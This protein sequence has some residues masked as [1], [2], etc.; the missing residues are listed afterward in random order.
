MVASRNRLVLLLHILPS[1]LGKW[2]LRQPYWASG[3]RTHVLPFFVLPHNHQPVCFIP[4]LLPGSLHKGCACIWTCTF[5]TRRYSF[6]SS[7]SKRKRKMKEI[8][9]N[10]YIRHVCT[11]SVGKAQT[12]DKSTPPTTTTRKSPSII[13]TGSSVCKWVKGRS[14]SISVTKTKLA[15]NQVNAKDNYAHTRKTE[16]KGN[17]L[18]ISP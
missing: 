8:G 17:G 9:D 3:Y 1:P 4:D 5:C 15:S 12:L 10:W 16:M 6:N 7:T 11:L 2:G 14:T 18:A 13:W